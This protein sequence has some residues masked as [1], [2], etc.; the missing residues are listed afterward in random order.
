MALWYE[1]L[2]IVPCGS[3]APSNAKPSVAAQR[4]GLPLIDTEHPF[5]NTKALIEVLPQEID[6]EEEARLYEEL[7]DVSSSSVWSYVSPSLTDIDVR[8]D[9]GP[10]RD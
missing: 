10:A 4:P 3:M 6:V 2:S 5:R 9:F 7:C 8:S 1:I